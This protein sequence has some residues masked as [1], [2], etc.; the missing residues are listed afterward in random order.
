VAGA[1]PGLKISPGIEID[2]P[3]GADEKKTQPDE[4]TR[5]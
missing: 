2:I 5:R 1:P 4:S 3:T